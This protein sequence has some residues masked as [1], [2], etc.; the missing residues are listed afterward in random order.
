MI[1]TVCHG[2][3]A[4]PFAP[5]TERKSFRGISGWIIRKKASRHVRREPSE[6][7]DTERGNAAGDID[8]F[9]SPPKGRTTVESWVPLRD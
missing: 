4:S 9:L 3:V 8:P 6:R 2:A 7:L 5:D 1:F